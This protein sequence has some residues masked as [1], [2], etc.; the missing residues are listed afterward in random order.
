[1]IKGCIV[2]VVLGVI[3][4]AG[5]GLLISSLIS[6]FENRAEKDIANVINNYAPGLGGVR[7][8][9]LKSNEEEGE[10]HSARPE[11]LCEC[12][13]WKK[14][15]NISVEKRYSIYDVHRDDVITVREH[16][17]KVRLVW[18]IRKTQND[19]TLGPIYSFNYARWD[20]ETCYKRYTSNSVTNVK[21][22]SKKHKF[23]DSPYNLIIAELP[24]KAYQYICEDCHM[25]VLTSLC[26]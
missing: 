21:R 9:G 4:L 20:E 6:D 17:G 13:E 3:C 12:Y 16:S 5:A 18:D 23:M 19:H 15:K 10:H 25:G 22:R 14:A 7:A 11:F 24:S 26:A 8:S 1:M 2:F